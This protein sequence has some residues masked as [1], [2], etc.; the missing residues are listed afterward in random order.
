MEATERKWNITN[1]LIY[2]EFH[3]AASQQGVVI[4]HLCLQYGGYYDILERL[5]IRTRTMYV[6]IAICRTQQKK[7]TKCNN[8]TKN[9]NLTK[10]YFIHFHNLQFNACSIYIS[11]QLR[12]FLQLRWMIGFEYKQME[13]ILLIYGI[14]T[15]TH[16]FSSLIYGQFTRKGKRRP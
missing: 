13:W 5:W 10:I 3:T 8:L 2:F 1:L 15:L 16:S 14:L 9:A 7:P 11:L 12:S 6:S 4:H